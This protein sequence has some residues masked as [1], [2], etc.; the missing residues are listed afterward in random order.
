MP[1][2]ARCGPRAVQPTQLVGQAFAQ[3]RKLVSLGAPL[4]RG[5]FF[6]VYRIVFKVDF[7]GIDIRRGRL[8]LFVAADRA[9]C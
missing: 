7:V 4:G 2:K 8:R 5:L 9:S 1:A 3:R 6:R